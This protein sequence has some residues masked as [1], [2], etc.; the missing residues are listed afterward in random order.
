MGQILIFNIS[1]FFSI[2]KTEFGIVPILLSFLIL[3]SNFLAAWETAVWSFGGKRFMFNYT[4]FGTLTGR[5]IN[6]FNL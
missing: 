1:H 4:L 2:S 3:S 5:L 6:S